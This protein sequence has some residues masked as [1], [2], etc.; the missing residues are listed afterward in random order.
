MQQK[1]KREEPLIVGRNGAVALSDYMAYLDECIAYE[2]SLEPLIDAFGEQLI[3]EGKDQKTVQLYKDA[4]SSFI[5]YLTLKTTVR[6]LTQITRAQACSQYT[7]WINKGLAPVKNRLGKIIAY[8][9]D[10]SQELKAFFIFLHLQQKMTNTKV[11]KALCTK[12]ELK[13]LGITL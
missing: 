1:E 7:R 13:E 12:E 10:Q 6:D 2:K 3:K 8:P 9:N 5:G 11:L 4:C